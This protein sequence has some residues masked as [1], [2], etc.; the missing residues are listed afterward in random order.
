ME[1]NIEKETWTT[2][3]TGTKI[4]QR[5]NSAPIIISH[6]W[7]TN[8]IFD[9]CTLNLLVTFYIY[10]MDKKLCNSLI[11]N[12]LQIFVFASYTLLKLKSISYKWKYRLIQ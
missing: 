7:G 6:F 3:K 10:L 8:I 11:C 1:S 12:Y 9:D 4:K 5:G 2:V